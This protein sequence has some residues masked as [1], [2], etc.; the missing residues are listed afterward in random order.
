MTGSTRPEEGMKP[1]WGLPKASLLK[2]LL[3]KLPA[4]L[5]ACICSPRRPARLTSGGSYERVPSRRSRSQLTP[6][7]SNHP[8]HKGLPRIWVLFS[9]EATLFHRGS[10]LI[11]LELRAFPDRFAEKC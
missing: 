1:F 6:D 3:G 5:G 10:D 2:R 11:P 4:P 9:G 7:V 8:R